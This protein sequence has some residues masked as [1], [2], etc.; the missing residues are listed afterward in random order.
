M[1]EVEGEAYRRLNVAARQQPESLSEQI[2]AVRAAGEMARGIWKLTHGDMMGAADIAAARAGRAAA[3]SIKES[4]TTDA[5]IKRAFAGFS[6]SPV[7]VEMPP[8]TRISP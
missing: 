8:P 2:G 7:P 3:T 1:I 4:Q 5:L 6:G